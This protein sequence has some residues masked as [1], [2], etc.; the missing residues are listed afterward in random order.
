MPTS[1][2]VAAQDAVARAVPVLA[3]V[4]LDEVGVR[5]LLVADE[6]GDAEHGLGRV[7]QL[8]GA[9]R[10]LLREDEADQVG[11]RL[12]GGVDVLLP[13]EAADLDERAAR[14]ARRASR[15]G[16]ARA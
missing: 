7:E 11:A 8:V 16:R 14:S 10:A 9:A 4:E 12:D 5:L 6:D 3:L 13:R 15:R 1:L 2:T